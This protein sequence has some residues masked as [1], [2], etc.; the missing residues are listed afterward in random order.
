MRSS[1]GGILAVAVAGVLCGRSA[2]GGGLSLI[3]EKTFFMRETPV[4]MRV[5]LGEEGDLTGKRLRLTVLSEAGREVGARD[6]EPLVFVNTVRFEGLPCGKYTVRAEL[7]ADKAAGRGP[8]TRTLNVQRSTRSAHVLDET[9][10]ASAEAWFRVIP[11]PEHKPRAG[12]RNGVLYADNAPFFMLG[13]GIDLNFRERGLSREEQVRL[14]DERLAELAEHGFNLVCPGDA[15]FSADYLAY[16]DIAGIYARTAGWGVR[17]RV[18]LM[19]KDRVGY[20]EFI[21]L[22]KKHGLAVKGWISPV[23]RS[24]ALTPR[25]IE[26]WSDLVLK[27]RDEENILFWKTE[28]ETDTWPEHNALL[29]RLFKEIDPARPVKLV[30]INA[31]R[32]NLGAADIHST[33]PYPIGD[34]DGIRSVATHC[35]RL[36]ALT[37]PDKSKCFCLW[38]QMY[39]HKHEKKVCPTPRQLRAMAFLAMNHGAKGLL[40]H[41]YQP[42]GQR[43]KN[44]W[45]L[46]DELFASMKTL[47]AQVKTMSVP[48]LI[49]KTVEGVGSDSPDVDV[50]AREYG[51]VVYVIAVNTSMRPLPLVRITLPGGRWPKRAEQLFDDREADIRG[52][53]IEAA[54]NVNDVR[55]YAVQPVGEGQK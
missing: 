4:D 19:P 52:D 7:F 20:S 2:F 40:Y 9:R 5:T 49:G 54:F 47:H 15:V 41:N 24:M 48:C 18:A 8:E 3:P 29:Y 38:L 53:T 17:E 23:T 1:V 51:G 36:K 37:G 35:D 25:Q 6:A 43:G 27:Y 44:D 30:V 14:F 12:I 34:G 50:A 28:D 21:A 39:G 45:E 31:V 13:T 55:V 42:A 11:P 26:V 46:T 10:E 33:D 22:A 32:P 16:P